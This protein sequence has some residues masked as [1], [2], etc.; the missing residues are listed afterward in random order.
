MRTSRRMLRQVRRALFVAFLFSGCIN[1]LML[2]TP[3]YI[4]QVFET[5]VPLAS[6]ET[7]VVLTAIAGGAILALGL[8]ELARDRI[9]LRAGLWLDHELGQH[10][11]ENGLKG[12]VQPSEMKADARA[13]EQFRAF[14]TSPAITPIFD[15]P[16]VPIFLIILYLLHPVIGL[17]AMGA[18]ALLLSAAII[19]AWAAGRVQQDIGEANERA[20]QWWMTLAGNGNLFGALGLANGATSQ[21]ERYNRAQIAGSYSLGK[22]TGFV[23]VCARTV[24]IGSQIALYAFGAWLVVLGEMTPGALVA[25]AILMARALSPLESLVAAIRGMRV[26]M[27]AYARLKALPADVSVPRIRA[28]AMAPDGQLELLD[29]NFYY[30]TRK[31]PALRGVSLVLEPGECLGIV[32]PNGSGKSTLASIIAGASRPTT[33]SADLEQIPIYKWQR[34]DGLMPPV[35][36]LSDEPLLIDGTVHDNIAR[37]RETSINSVVEAAIAAGVHETLQGLQSGYDTAVGPA[38]SYLSMRERRA[39]ALARAVHGNPSVIVLDEPEIGLD[40]ASLRA[41]TKVLATLKQSGRSLVIATQDPRLLALTDKIA[42]LAGGALQSLGPASEFNKRFEASRTLTAAL[43]G[44]PS[45]PP[46]PVSSGEEASP[47]AVAPSPQVKPVPEPA[48]LH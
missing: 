4:L 28:N 39:V 36:Y 48:G 27:R 1:I 17:V 32:G 44:V 24:R 16:W 10:L 7:L 43:A 6:L 2:A 18:A 15:A 38:G 8:I 13:L 47:S 14:L 21:W 26:G 34:G 30:P 12:G 23:K 33:G 11:L 20:E 45:K 37:F 25:S 35:G 40:G 5:V 19:Q 42:L 31:T 29:V 46:A 22:R 3:L 41:L 9:L